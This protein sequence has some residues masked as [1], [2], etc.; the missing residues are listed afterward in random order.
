MKNQ[1]KIHEL[2]Q[3]SSSFLLER[4]PTNKWL[5]TIKIL[6]ATDNGNKKTT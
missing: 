4:V 5:T 3:T 2:F 1:A 6:R